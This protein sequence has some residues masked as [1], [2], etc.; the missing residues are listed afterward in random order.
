[1]TDIF[2]STIYFPGLY[3]S[4]GL[5]E[6]DLR[7]QAFY[8]DVLKFYCEQKY[9]SR[10]DAIIQG[11]KLLAFGL[12]KIL[13]EPSDW[14]LVMKIWEQ[15]GQLMESD[16]SYCYDKSTP[17]F[18]LELKFRHKVSIILKDSKAI[19]DG[20]KNRATM[21][22]LEHEL[23]T[24]REQIHKNESKHDILKSDEIIKSIYSLCNET[25]FECEY[26]TFRNCIETANFENLNIKG[27]NK[28]QYLAYMLSGIMD[29][30][31]YSDICKNMDW[32]KDLCSGKRT[33]IKE[34]PW[35]KKFEKILPLPKKE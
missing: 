12:T 27:L 16:E 2:Y 25:I 8:T 32:R 22:K 17:E 5:D 31:W 13:T 29:D 24:A 30:R 26:A 1:M 23:S 9:S 10:R 18:K 14:I 20:K 34:Q 33:K 21:N 11:I 15:G 4:G 6:I 19:F 7:S 35:T 3:S 28:V